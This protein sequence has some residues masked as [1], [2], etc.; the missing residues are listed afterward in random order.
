MLPPLPQT[1]GLPPQILAESPAPSPLL[2]LVRVAVVV[3]VAFGCGV[4]KG[5]GEACIEGDDGG[6]SDEGT[7]GG[8][9]GRPGKTSWER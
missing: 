1:R 2:R 4:A 9:G 7:D 8:A 6:A 5:T 3:A